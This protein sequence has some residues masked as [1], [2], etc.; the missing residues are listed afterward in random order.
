MGRKKRVERGVRTGK[1]RNEDEYNE[2]I[3]ICY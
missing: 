1:G 3:G 2:S